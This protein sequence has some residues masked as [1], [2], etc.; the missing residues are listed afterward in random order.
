MDMNELL[1]EHQISL[2]RASAGRR[3]HAL[4]SRILAAFYALRIRSLRASWGLPQV[5]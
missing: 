4:V 3:E 2:L 1:R 5:F